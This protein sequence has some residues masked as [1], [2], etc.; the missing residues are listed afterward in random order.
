M[1]ESERERVK[2]EC[3]PC[4]RLAEINQC[5]RQIQLQTFVMLLNIQIYSEIA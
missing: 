1:R 4:Y 2:D 5:V 3:Q